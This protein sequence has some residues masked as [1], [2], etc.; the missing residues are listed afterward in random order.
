[1]LCLFLKMSSSNCLHCFCTEDCQQVPVFWSADIISLPD[2]LYAYNAM[3]KNHPLL[4]SFSVLHVKIGQDRQTLDFCVG[5]WSIPFLV[6][7]SCWGSRIIVLH[8][9]LQ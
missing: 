9:A 1:M 2:V 7:L 6:K 5:L 4:S 8:F 3:P